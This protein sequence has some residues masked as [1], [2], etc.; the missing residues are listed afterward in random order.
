MIGYYV[1]HHGLGH[2]HRAAICAQLRPVVTA[3]TL[4]D[5]LTARH[6]GDRDGG[7]R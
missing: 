1:H 3:M 2:L 5:N 4:L 7:V 6:P